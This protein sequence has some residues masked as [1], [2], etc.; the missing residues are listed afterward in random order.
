MSL[1]RSRIVPVQMVH[2]LGT[3]A[4]QNSSN[5]SIGNLILTNP[6]AANY[7]GT[8]VASLTALLTAMG[9]AKTEDSLTLTNVSN[10]GSS[11]VQDM[12][13]F[14]IPGA[15]QSGAIVFGRFTV[16]PSL[17]NTITELALSLKYASNFTLFTQASGGVDSDPTASE[18]SFNGKV[19][20]DITNDRLQILFK[21]PATLAT[22]TMSILA[23]YNIK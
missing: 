19:S 11:T 8:G 6:L 13:T 4:L 23:G 21:S 17:A 22:Y 9:F 15:S 5:V 16:T 3:M 20:A 14:R 2:G 12:T 10:V 18:R 7:G 1:A